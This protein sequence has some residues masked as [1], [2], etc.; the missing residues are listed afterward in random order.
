[1]SAASAW[2]RAARRRLNEPHHPR[3]CTSNLNALV[4]SAHLDFLL[5]V[6]VLRSLRTEVL[7]TFSCFPHSSVY[8]ELLGELSGIL[9]CTAGFQV[10]FS[11][12][13]LIPTALAFSPP[14]L[15]L[16]AGHAAC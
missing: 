10:R 1:M 5:Q 9:Q 2:P 6:A 13:L 12:D 16:R 15:H 3:C 7:R 4:L 14:C 8:C 11:A